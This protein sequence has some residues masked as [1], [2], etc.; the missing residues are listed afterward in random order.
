MKKKV[1]EGR[2]NNRNYTQM[3][4]LKKLFIHEKFYTI[5]TTRQK[6]YINFD[7]ILIKKLN[8]DDISN[9][10]LKDYEGFLGEL[11]YSIN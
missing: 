11:Y 10:L 1:V 2:I 6:Q 7:I 9:T 4:M 5:F 3:S 8:K